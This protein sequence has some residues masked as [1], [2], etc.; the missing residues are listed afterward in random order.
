M[1]EPTEKLKKLIDRFTDLFV[2]LKQPG[3]SESDARR[4]FID[5]LFDELGWDIHNAGGKPLSLREVITENMTSEGDR[6]DYIFTLSGIPK[7]FVEAKKPSVDICNDGSSSRQARRYGW[8][9]RHPF[10]VLTNF[11]YLL[12]YDTNNPPKETD[13]SQTAL[14]KKYHYSEYVDKWEEIA[15]PLSRYTVYSGQ[16]EEVY[17][18]IIFEGPQMPVDV[19]FLKQVNKWRVLLGTNIY[20][21][22]PEYDIDYIDFLVQT[23]INQIVFLRICE[24]RNLP[25]YHTLIETTSNPE[26]LKK[27]LLN[28]FEEAEKKYNSGLFSSD[29]VVFN[30]NNDIIMN[31]IKDLY[32]P[33]SSYNFNLISSNLLGYIYEL[34]LSEKLTLDKVDEIVLE[35]KDP[36]VGRDIVATPIEIV[37]YM[38][39]QT[40]IQKLQDKIPTEILNIRIGDIACGSGV[41]LLE[42][43]ENLI[44]IVTAWY[45]NNDQDHLVVGQDGDLILPFEDKKNI[46]TNCIYGID[47]DPRAVEVARF[48]LL[49][50]LIENENKPSLSG[51]NSVLPN[52]NLNIQQ[53]NSLIDYGMIGSSKLTDVELISISPLDWHFA[54]ETTSFD[55]ILGNPPYVTTEDLIASVTD[56]EFQIYKK[57]Y[58]SAYKQFDKY[59]LFIERAFKSLKED[60][61]MCYIVPNKFAKIKSGEKIRDLLTSSKSVYEYINFKS[62][63][64]FGGK[65]IYSSILTLT[66]NEMNC[67]IYEDVNDL[68]LW[69]ANQAITTR[70]RVEIN[71]AILTEN[72]W[73]LTSDPNETAI[74]NHMFKNSIPLA[75]VADT[76]NGIQ[77]S[78]ERPKSI[79]W[80][81][82]DE[83]IEEKESHYI[84]SK[85]NKTYKIEKSILKPFFKPTKKKEKNLGSYDIALTDKMIIFPYDSNGHLF[86]Q[87]VME[88]RFPFTWKY[89]TDNYERLVPRQ[90]SGDSS[91]RDVPHATSETW[92]H[93]GRI[94]ALTSFIEQPKL[95]VG[96]LRKEP[97]YIYD[98]CDLLIASGGTAGYCA[99]TKKV[100][101]P[102]EL[103]YIQAVLNHPATELLCSIIGSDFEGQ[104]HSRG[105]YVLDRLPIPNIDFDNYR[106]V[107]KYQKIIDNTKRIY[108]INKKLIRP[109]LAIKTGISFKRE[110]EHCIEQITSLVSTLF[111]I[112]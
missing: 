75:Q 103:E 15:E 5:L 41:F 63:Q 23:F 112:S 45:V 87:E 79:Y 86:S 29:Y 83:V 62:A 12:I 48:S 108:E 52:L 104:F 60:G 14:I 73:V 42:A 22:N 70:S 8:N 10:S 53:G 50:K 4:E 81:S 26:I 46:L 99:I 106:E 30:L 39:G 72:P 100:G 28:V 91:H 110:K 25:L 92:Y 43:F 89:L 94:Q 51:K 19:Y 101:S 88:S 96:V 1:I 68:Q 32:F 76:F 82:S 56:R 77:T 40:L 64:L 105:T 6:P 2:Q 58:D 74:I 36:N 18:N 31:I 80:F 65:T 9:A 7:F 78:A 61:I 47:I 71:S 107:Q 27:E 69:W 66:K 3:Y 57:K 98:D 54:N 20:K 102:Y 33:E 85:F 13:N 37:K 16:F 97:M 111:A 17:K 67:L 35:A 44:N 11:E 109:G 49:L 24:D 38:V 90:V 21:N 93:Y 95:I 55:I 84:I 59:F 34:F